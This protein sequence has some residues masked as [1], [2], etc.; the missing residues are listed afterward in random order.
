MIHSIFNQGLISDII[1]IKYKNEIIAQKLFLK[2]HTSAPNDWISA[3]HGTKLKNLESIIKYGLKSQGTKLPNGQFVPK[4]KYEP[5]E[6][7]VLGIRNWQ[8]AIFAT[9]CPICASTYSDSDIDGEYFLA[10]VLVEIRIKPGNFTQHQSKELIGRVGHHNFLKIIHNDTY[11]RILL[12]EDVTIK[13]ITFISMEYLNETMGKESDYPESIRE[14]FNEVI[15][16]PRKE[17][18]ELNNLFS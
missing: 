2:N 1:P 9:P 17:L 14:K 11:Y 5:L 6:E 8:N 4:T 15:V 7:I 13:S 16:K 10:S 12:D 3:W 18:Q